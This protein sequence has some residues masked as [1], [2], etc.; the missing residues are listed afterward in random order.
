M[1]LRS[2]YLHHFRNYADAYFTFNPGINVIYGDNGQGKTNL[3]EAIYFLIAG[4]SF[5]NVQGSDLIFREQPNFF[6]EAN[7]VKRGIEQKLRISFNGKE[8]RVIYNNT[9]CSSISDLLGLLHG[10]VMTP[11]DATLVKGSPQIRRQFLDVHI[12]QYAP[13]YVHHLT[14]YNR[15]MRQRNHLLRAKNLVS[16]E[17]WEHEMSKAAAYITKQR[18]ASLQDLNAKGLLLHQMLSGPQETLALHYKTSAPHQESEQIVRQYYQDQYAS[19]RRREMD[20]GATLSG[21]HKD[22]VTILINHQD[23]RYFASEGQQRSCTTAL[24]LAKWA[25]LQKLTEESPLMLI[26]DIGTSLDNRRRVNFLNQLS[27]LG[28]VFISA[29]TPLTDLTSNKE[30]HHFNIEQGRLISSKE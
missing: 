24:G 29:T 15:A 30:I 2:L 22:D 7:F 17:S 21:P 26:D 6:I 16:I 23:A 19:Q 20:L 12:A 9:V 27:G 3:L 13:L 1:F 10:V 11:D 28:Q 8:R 4:H 25:C 14:R 5:R 18:D